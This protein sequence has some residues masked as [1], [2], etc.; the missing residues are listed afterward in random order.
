MRKRYVAA[1]AAL[2]IAAA[3]SVLALWPDGTSTDLMECGI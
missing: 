2:P 3:T 1:A